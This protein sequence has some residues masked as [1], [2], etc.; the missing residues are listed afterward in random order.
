MYGSALVPHPASSPTIPR[1]APIRAAASSSRDAHAE[2][3]DTGTGHQGTGLSRAQ[4]VW[5]Y[6]HRNW[7]HLGVYISPAGN[8]IHPQALF[9][10]Y[11][12]WRRRLW[13]DLQVGPHGQSRL[14]IHPGRRNQTKLHPPSDTGSR[15]AA[16]SQRH[17]PLA[18]PVWRRWLG[19]RNADAPLWFTWDPVA[20]KWGFQ[21]QK[22]EYEP[23]P[24]VSTRPKRSAPSFDIPSRSSAARRAS[25]DEIDRRSR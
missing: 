4:P 9:T 14:K 23:A 20:T 24:R 25:R 5:S 3:K 2:T 11:H 6:L 18:F 13:S 10:S 7:G 16:G 12:V 21:C 15:S 1:G 22:R 8:P 17:R 19:I